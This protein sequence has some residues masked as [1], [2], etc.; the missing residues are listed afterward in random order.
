[1]IVLTEK[2][3]VAKDIAAGLGGFKK[4]SF[5]NSDEK[6]RRD[7]YYVNGNDCIVSSAGHLLSLY[8]PSDYDPKFQTWNL[9]DLPIIPSE[10]KYKPI[11]ATENILKK[12]RY[13]FQNF[14]NKN[15]VLATD[16]EREGEYIGYLILKDI[17]F[18]EY[19]SAKRFWVSQALTPEVVKKGFQELKPLSNFESYRNA[20][21]ARSK[22]DW[23]LG[24][25]V[26]RLI[27]LSTKSNMFFGRIQTAIL[28]AIYVRDM[29]IKNFKSEPFFQLQISAGNAVFTYEENEKN[30]F[31]D[32][33][34]LSKLLDLINGR[35]LE[36]TDISTIKKTENP[37]QLFNITG[38][39]KYCA[40]TY[41]LTPEE[42][43]NCAQS[44]YEKHK[45]L[46][47]PRTPSVVLGDDNTDLFRTKFD[48]LSEAYP[49][50]A[51]RCTRSKISSD[52]KRIFN[53][54]KLQDHHA[55]IPLAVLPAD[56]TENEKNVYYAVLKRFFDTIKPPYE[57]G[58]TTVTGNAEGKIFKAKGKTVYNEGWK[59]SND[60]DAEDELIEI[61][62]EIKT[63]SRFTIESSEITEGK[64]QPKK[65][66]TNATILALMENPKNEDDSSGR[67]IGIGTPATRAGF[68]STL[69]KRGYII[70]KGQ[71]LL[72]TEKGI[73]LIKTIL[74][75]PSLANLIKLSTTTEWEQK[76]S[77]NPEDFL[78]ENEKFLRGKLPEIK[79]TETY[80]EE[81]QGICI[82]PLCKKGNVIASKKTGNYF[83]S[84]Y[85]E[86]C[87]FIVYK[88]NIGNT[89]LTSSDITALCEGKLT[90][91]KKMTSKSGSAYEARLKAEIKDGKF[92]L[93]RVFDKRKK[94]KN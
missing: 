12:I 14:D 15:F 45:C 67:L 40:N 50:L 62:K 51:Q 85:K 30:K 59:S 56:T 87:S 44:L 55:L 68:I 65:H 60:K 10:Y 23:L 93:E 27:A 73:F 89:L 25:N 5:G 41:H 53:S 8:M 74:K 28:G 17:G 58:I 42:T 16:A 63:G 94:S 43:L 39:Q 29:N 75:I 18:K 32:S 38:L 4:V 90:K 69:L 21:A 57:Y 19:S 66:Y 52:N 6:G 22:S 82:C 71:Q 11:P 37:P 54:E 84:K 2:P 1:M 61:P 9:S 20:G 79:I 35:Q 91:K 88:K 48:I 86:G 47:Y 33:S 83:C 36:I 31:S 7:F 46:S 78:K 26:S 13:C 3:S 34:A 49:E 72:I 70:Q 77:E 80:K 24:I 76:L 81:N 64:T 92:Q